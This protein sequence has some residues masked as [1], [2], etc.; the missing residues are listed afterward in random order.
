MR[1]DYFKNGFF[2][3]LSEKFSVSGNFIKAA[4]VSAVVVFAGVSA[5]AQT[6]ASL[7]TSSNPIVSMGAAKPLVAWSKFCDSN[8]TECAVDVREPEVV[9]LTPQVWKT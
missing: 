7:P 3:G 9:D 8:P 4:L 1:Q 6:L 2:S 5:Q